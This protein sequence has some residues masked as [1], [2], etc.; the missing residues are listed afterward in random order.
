[1]FISNNILIVKRLKIF[2]SFFNFY[3]CIFCARKHSSIT[4]VKYKHLLQYVTK[5]NPLQA[6]N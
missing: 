2:T 6:A 4:L 3:S 5:F 1:M